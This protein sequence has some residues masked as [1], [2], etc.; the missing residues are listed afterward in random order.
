MIAKPATVTLT[1]EEYFALEAVENERRFEF[2]D[3]EIIDMTGGT[4]NHSKIKINVM[5]TL[6]GQ[7]HYS[8]CTLRNSDMRVKISD[9]RYVYPDLSAVC[10]APQLED[11]DTTLLNPIMVVEVTSA[12]SKNYDRGQKP[13]FYD[14]V[15]SIQVY[16]VVDQNRLFVDLHTRSGPRWIW[17]EFKHPDDVIPIEALDCRLPLTEVY[18]GISFETG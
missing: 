6:F 14:A 12:T 7:L 16:L 8:D 13:E 9:T 11:N 4:N 17:E 2:I 18:S 15:P 1:V 10:G 3:G 5:G